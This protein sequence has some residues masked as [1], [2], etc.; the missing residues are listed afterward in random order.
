MFIWRHRFRAD[1]SQDHS[2]AL[3]ATV[4]HQTGNARELDHDE[5]GLISSSTIGVEA[6][7]GPLQVTSTSGNGYVLSR[8]RHSMMMMVMMMMIS[9]VD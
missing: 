8:T 9:A 3:R 6:N 4:S 1:L 5:P 2:R 7:A